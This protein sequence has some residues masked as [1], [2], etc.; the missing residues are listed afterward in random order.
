VEPGAAVETRTCVVCEGAYEL[1]DT[2]DC[3]HHEGT[4]CSLCCSLDADC[5]DSC[6]RSAR[7]DGPV[8]LGMPTGP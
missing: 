4:I 6:T 8:L 5:H 1:P 3:P 2:A 7:A